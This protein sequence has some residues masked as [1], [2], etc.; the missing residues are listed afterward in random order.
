MLAADAAAEKKAF[1]VMALEVRELLV[2]TDYFVLATGRTDRQVKT[3]AE[4]VE[5]LLRE[6]AGRKPIGREGESEGKWVL[7]DYGDVVVH[8]FTPEER[9]FYRLE[10]LWADA[11][12]I[13][14]PDDIVNPMPADGVADD[15]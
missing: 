6:T 7:L 4:E 13:P 5:R 11:P 10:R 15:A 1:D 14:L 9:A 8:V 3:I 12:R 2:I